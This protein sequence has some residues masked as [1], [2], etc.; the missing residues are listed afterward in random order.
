MTENLGKR[1]NLIAQLLAAKIPCT[2]ISL[3]N[4][5]LRLFKNRKKWN[6]GGGFY[7]S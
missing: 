3:V 6:M 2:K 7:K 4:F 5:L 1:R